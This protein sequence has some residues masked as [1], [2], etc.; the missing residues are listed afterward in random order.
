MIDSLIRVS[1]YFPYCLTIVDV[2]AEGRPCLFANEKFF[3]NTGFD[4]QYGIGRNLSYLQG[5][6]TSKETITFMRNCF[7]EKKSCIQ[8]IINYKKDGT[9]FLNRLLLLP[10]I[11]NTEELYYVGFQNDITQIKGLD[12]NNTSLTK[13]CDD[14]IKH[15]VNN[16]LNIILGKMSL[17]FSGLSN[18]EEINIAVK[19]L[20]CFF[21]RINDY[22]LNIEDV[23]DF[24][25]FSP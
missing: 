12:Y 21:E 1:D 10:I 15:M 7:S 22:A 6:L 4:S 5:K 20:S 13:I 11:T 9:P 2:M 18:D 16:P 3:K 14:E 8:D 25:H 24:E 19:S 23:S 17:A